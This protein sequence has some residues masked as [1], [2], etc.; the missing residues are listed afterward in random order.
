MTVIS[1]YLTTEGKLK[2]LVEHGYTKDTLL[3]ES[4]TMLLERTNFHYFL[5]YARNYRSLIRAEKVHPD[6][7]ID[8]IANIVRFDHELS[9]LIFGA[10]QQFEW[11]LRAAIV[12]CH[13]AYFAPSDCFLES[14]HFIREIDS[15]PTVESLIYQQTLRSKEPYL[16]EHFQQ[17]VHSLGLSADTELL[18]LSSRERNVL[19]KSLPIWTM[20]DNWTLGLLVRFTIYSKPETSPGRK[21]F[22]E[23]ASRFGV[24]SAILTTQLD[25]IVALRNLVAHH[26]RL[27]MRPTTYTPKIPK[28]YSNRGRNCDSKSMYAATLALASFLRQDEAESHFL[29]SIDSLLAANEDFTLGIQRPLVLKK[30]STAV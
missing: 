4:T 11:R 18:S 17:V 26:S 7:P 1:P 3:H 14:E 6:S 9:V 15:R 25:S 16:V 23:V 8:D 2:Y 27:W 5:G 12:D 21:L 29:K 28:L 30:Y 19:L 22:K 13:C 20:V 24:S 10:L